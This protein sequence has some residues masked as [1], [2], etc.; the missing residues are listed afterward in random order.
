M[1]AACARAFGAV[2]SMLAGVERRLGRQLGAAGW[3]PSS[4]GRGCRGACHC[5]RLRGVSYC[6][7]PEVESLLPRF[8]RSNRLLR[9]CSC[10]SPF[11]A[12]RLVPW[13]ACCGCVWGVLGLPDATTSAIHPS[14]RARCFTLAC[15]DKDST[16]DDKRMQCPRC[17]VGIQLRW[18]A[19]PLLL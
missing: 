17:A 8:S 19:R 3:H 6:D 10:S 7:V 12:A 4:L 18:W 1:D 2:W 15:V 16:A 14:Y 13:G 9:R 11:S 5:C